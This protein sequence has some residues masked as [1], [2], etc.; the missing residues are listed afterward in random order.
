MGSSDYRLLNMVNDKTRLAG[1]NKMELLLFS[2][3]GRETF[4]IN[5]FKV[6]EVCE[7]LAVTATPNMPAGVAGIVSLRGAILPVLDLSKCLRLPA[8]AAPGKLIIT[9]FSGHTQGFLVGDVD[10][11]VRVDWEQVRAPQA[12]LAQAASHVTAL[13]ELGDGRLVA[14][15]DVEQVLAEVMGEEPVPPLAAI[16]D[17]RGRWVF[18]A[19]D[20]AVARRKIVQVLEGL[21]LAHQQAHNGRE[22]WEKL[23]ALAAQA[24]AEK[25]PLAET[26]GLVLVDAEMPEMDG[27]V[28]TRS[29]KAD[30][31]FAGIPVLMHSSL[32]SVANKKLGQQVGVDAYVAKFRPEELAETIARMLKGQ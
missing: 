31:R 20:S 6:R 1:S 25:R 22:A 9:E 23:Q 13:T 26:L 17:A 19:D 14:I 8:G 16:A 12:L 24:E 29:I 11:I 2:L 28:L 30:A 18:F 21:K 32:S 27:Y 15:L 7:A 10:R 4:G 3:G 5:V